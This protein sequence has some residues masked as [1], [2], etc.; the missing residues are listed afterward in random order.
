M[1]VF[2]PIFESK[3]KEQFPF[4]K[5]DG[6][7][8]SLE[9]FLNSN[10]EESGF[11][12]EWNNG[13]LEVEERLKP[14]EAVLYSNLHNKFIQNELLRDGYEMISEM[15]CYLTSQKK[16][17]IPDIGIFSKQEIRNF[18][19][20]NSFFPVI[21]IEI[22]SPSNQIEEMELKIKD[23]FQ[24]GVKSVWC[25]FPRLKEIRIYTSSKQ[26]KIYTDNDICDAGDV[27]PDFR[28]SV[29]EIFE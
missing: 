26:V 27:I 23:Y 1:I 21:A 2:T 13:V 11:K 4:P 19:K 28:I 22:I 20:G 24:E 29:R 16:V 5:Y 10:F 18:K 25:I 14:S 3:P 7:Q 15:E 9:D 17:R 8:M 12:Y 6:I